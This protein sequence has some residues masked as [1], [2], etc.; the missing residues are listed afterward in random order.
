MKI[1]SAI[2]TSTRHRK[3]SKESGIVAI[4][5]FF[6]LC[7]AR[8]YGATTRK[9]SDEKYPRTLIL[10][11]PELSTPT[12]SRQT[13]RKVSLCIDLARAKSEALNNIYSLFK[14]NIKSCNAK[15]RRQRRRTVKNNNTSKGDVT[16]DD[17]Q[18]QFLEQHSYAM[19]EQCSN[20]SKQCR[21]NVTTLCCAKNR[22][23]E[24]PRVT[25]P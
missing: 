7:G 24:S 2:L 19:L 21:N 3:N 11:D 4:D 10:T 5:S 25:S 15:R 23:C 22:R 6:A 16:R 17:S 18:R 14:Q 8:Q 1:N 9:R 13:M 20:Y 12:E